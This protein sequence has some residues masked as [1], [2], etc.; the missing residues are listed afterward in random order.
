MKPYVV[1]K[2]KIC[3]GMHQSARYVPVGTAEGARLGHFR[4]DNGKGARLDG[5]RCEALLKNG[6]I[7]IFSSGTADVA[8][9][10]RGYG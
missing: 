9:S 10:G 3:G 6:G 2:V 1:Q 4:I 5:L 7:H 8:L